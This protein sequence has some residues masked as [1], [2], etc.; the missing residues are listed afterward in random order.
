MVGPFE[1]SF[2]VERLGEG[3]CE[4]ELSVVIKLQ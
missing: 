2:L 1:N 4:I 3:L